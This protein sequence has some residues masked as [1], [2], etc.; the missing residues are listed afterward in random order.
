[1][2]WRVPPLFVE[3]SATKPPVFTTSLA[4][5]LAPSPS[6]R[7][8]AA[9]VP[10]LA[11]AV[12]LEEKGAH[13]RFLTEE[14]V[15]GTAIWPA[16]ATAAIVGKTLSLHFGTDHLPRTG[17]VQ[18]V[19]AWVPPHNG[20]K[21]DGRAFSVVWTDAACLVRW[22]QAWFLPVKTPSHDVVVTEHLHRITR[23]HAY[24]MY[25]GGNL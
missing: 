20:Q 1:M 22:T 21:A 17:T 6:R 10:P 3:V 7:L 8:I 15:M 25:F 18:R 11:L 4:E 9:V 2:L 19:L 13:G 14:D 16:D 12:V 23:S 5:L 24:G